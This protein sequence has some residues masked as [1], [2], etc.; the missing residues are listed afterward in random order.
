MARR[1]VTNVI[2]LSKWAIKCSNPWWLAWSYVNFGGIFLYLCR[3]H[4]KYSSL[5]LSYHD[6]FVLLSCFLLFLLLILS[7]LIL[8]SL[9]FLVPVKWARR[10]LIQSVAIEETASQATTQ[11]CCLA[12]VSKT[13]RYAVEFKL[14]ISGVQRYVV[15]NLTKTSHL[16]VDWL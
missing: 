8:S 5:S 11:G 3:K 6:F 9:L 13:V 16:G 2:H 15:D 10:S 4:S 7:S 14:E 12:S 1:I